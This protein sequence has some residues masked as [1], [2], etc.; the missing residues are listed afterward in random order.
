MW[1]LLAATAGAAEPEAPLL[2][3]PP[4][5]GTPPKIEW[6]VR[7]SD[8]SALDTPTFFQVTDAPPALRDEFTRAQNDRMT[9]GVALA[10]TGMAIAIVGSITSV[11]VAASTYDPETGTGA[12]FYG[13]ALGTGVV[14][15]L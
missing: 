2:R 6:I 5:Y 13:I 3:E 12:E 14:G 11:V 4:P 9:V 1:L 10:A 15:T 7:Y 8:G